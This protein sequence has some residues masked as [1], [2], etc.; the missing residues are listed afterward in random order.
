M[1]KKL[2][3]R[4]FLQQATAVGGATLLAAS[5]AGAAIPAGSPKGKGGPPRPYRP[6][7]AE[8]KQAFERQKEYDAQARLPVYQAKI[9]PYWFAEN[10][11]FWYRN[12]LAGGRR[13]FV[14]VDAGRGV[15]AAAF[16]HARLAAGLSKASG[17][18]YTADHLPIQAIE[19]TPQKQAVRFAADGAAWQCDLA[20]Y[21]C[22]RIAET[23]LTPTAAVTDQKP[24]A[25]GRRSRRGHGLEDA[26]PVF[27]RDHNLWLRAEGSGAETALTHDGTADRPYGEIALSPDAKTFAAYRIDPAPIKPVYMV[28][29][30]PKDGGTRGVLHQHEYAQPGDPFPL[31]EMWVFDAATGSGVKAQVEKIAVGGTP[32]LHWRKD[33]RTFLYERADRGHQFFQIVEVTVGT[34]QSRIIADE[35][36]K[37]FIN[38]SNVYTYYSRD[39]AEVLYASEMDGWRHL[40]RYDA[41]QGKLANQVT[42]GE[43]VVRSVDRVDEEAGQIW[44]QA[45]GRNPGEDPYL[46]HHYRVNF[47]GTGLVA[48]TEGNGTH[49]VQ[50]SPDNAYLIDSYSRADLPPVHVLRKVSDGSLVC[51]LEEADVSAP[52]AGGWHFPEVFR[53]KGRDGVTDIWGIV[54]RPTHLDPAKKYPIIENIYAGPQ[55]SF[56]RKTFAVRDSMQALA[57]LG[58]IVVQCDGMGT[59]NRSKAFHDVCWHNLKD[60]GFSDR[61]AWM[62][63]LAAKHPYCDTERV[64]VYGTSAGGQNSTGALLFHPEFYKVGVS[65]CG[66]HDNRIDKQWWNEQWM[67]YPVGPWYDDSSNIV[68]AEN[69]RGKLLL[70]VG[71][72]DTNVPPESTLRLTGALQKAAKDYDLIV[73]IGQDHGSGGV[74]GERRRR[75]YFV[76]H[77]LGVEPPDRNIPTPPPTPV[78]LTPRSASEES[79]AQ[80]EGGADTSIRFHNRTSRAVLLFWLPGDGTRKSYGEIA[81][82]ES[83]EIHTYSS[84]SWL[85]T[86][87][88]GPPLAVFVG[89]EHP[90]IAEIR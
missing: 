38:T 45:S 82:G 72:L 27:V 84:H 57:D 41:V 86:V 12:D 11:S 36:A 44:F 66:C 30:S 43:W 40:Y 73:S 65:S 42:H 33:G 67:G 21:A 7:R 54:F 20:S 47:D 31:Y 28:E 59:R 90:G 52:L 18:V 75:D 24:G 2:S 8:I 5:G 34:G 87:K 13:R 14:C 3:R 71:E 25:E 76:R 49:A 81:P 1:E 69:L 50:Y 61:I 19:Y 26:A 58:F 74:Y 23:D 46:L 60:A 10:T 53:A 88:D 68:H 85:V 17:K 15:R 4:K 22:T 48:L 78:V 56:V 89:E 29:S 63:A 79:L 83:R 64:G 77:L 16:D 80:G 39:A 37:T 6:T 55:D 35:R 32:D 62:K 70:L 51:P 9:T